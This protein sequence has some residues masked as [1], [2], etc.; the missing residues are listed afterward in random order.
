VLCFFSAEFKGILYNIVTLCKCADGLGCTAI[1]VP[2]LCDN[3]CEQT[4]LNN[5][6]GVAVPEPCIETSPC[7]AGCDC[8]PNYYR[9]PTGACVSAAVC[10]EYS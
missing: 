7:T 5:I 8:A 3:T 4:C 2:L 10:S 9:D 6:L 1:Q